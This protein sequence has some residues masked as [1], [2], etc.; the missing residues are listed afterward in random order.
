MKLRVI[1]HGKAFDWFDIEEHQALV[2]SPEFFAVLQAR[3]QEHFRIPMEHQIFFGVGSESD[4]VLSTCDEVRRSILTQMRG[5]AQTETAHG[6][7]GM[8]MYL[9]C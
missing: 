4:C 8:L 9:F 7:S 1:C 6:A 3:A 5:E 2:D